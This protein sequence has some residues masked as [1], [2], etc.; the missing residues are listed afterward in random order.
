MDELLAKG[1]EGARFAKSI[2]RHSML[3]GARRRG[4]NY[5]PTSGRG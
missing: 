1:Q 2:Q 3:I 4:M 5:Q